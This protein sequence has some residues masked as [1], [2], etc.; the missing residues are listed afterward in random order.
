MFASAEIAR[1]VTVA[2][3]GKGLVTYLP[4]TL[5]ERLGYFKDAGLNVQIN[6]FAGGS[7]S[8]ESLVGG[9]VDIAAAAYEHTLLLQRKGITLIAIATFNTSYGCVIALKPELAKKYKSPTDLKGLKIGATAPGTAGAMA[10]SILLSKANLPP[11]AV[12]II[13]IGG[14]PGALAA[15]KAGELDGVSQFDPVITQLIHDGDMVPIV[16]TRT[17]EGMK[18]LYGGYI[19][20]SSILT[21]P[22]FIAENPAATKAFAGAIGR[23][24]KWL[25]TATPEQVAATVPQAYLGANPDLYKEAVKIAKATFTDDGAIPAEAAENNYRLLSTYG[26]LVGVKDINVKTSYDNSFVLAN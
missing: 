4:L 24:V 9:S 12:S 17:E 19:A 15:A 20:A 13:G 3:G 2:I 23:A 11:S 6:D 16:D 1:P 25:K 5:A 14:G 10:V 21:T 22:K 7:K 26:P 8:I 18:Y